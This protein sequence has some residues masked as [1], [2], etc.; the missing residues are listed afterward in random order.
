MGTSECTLAELT[1]KGIK[2]VVGG[3]ENEHISLRC[4]DCDMASKPDICKPI[5]GASFDDCPF[6]DKNE[7]LDLNS[8]FTETEAPKKRT[9][10]PKGAKETK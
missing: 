10:A 8:C 2:L 4:P 6:F 3:E 5:S 1:K 7:P 9:L